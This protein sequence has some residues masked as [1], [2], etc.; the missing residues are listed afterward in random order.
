MENI[1]LCLGREGSREV[2]MIGMAEQ[3]LRDDQN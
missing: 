1:K 2:A 3:I